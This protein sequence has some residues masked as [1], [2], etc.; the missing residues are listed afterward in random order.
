MP[1]PS[2]PTAEKTAGPE[3]T[4]FSVFL[5]NKVGALLDVVKLLQENSVLVLALCLVECTETS[6]GRMVVSDPQKARELFASRGVPFSECQVLL[7]ELEEGAAEVASFLTV[8]LMA[9]VNLH[10][11]YPLLIRPRGKAVLVVNVE[12][13]DYAQ[14]VLRREGY[15]LLRQTDISR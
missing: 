11:C 15:C 9:E 2:A 5:P 4:Q 1:R 14:S 6:I 12:D 10:F 8:L 13:S 3:V 7:V